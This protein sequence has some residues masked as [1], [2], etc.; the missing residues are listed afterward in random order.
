MIRCAPLLLMLG[1]SSYQVNSDAANGSDASYT[2]ANTGTGSSDTDS[3]T[4][5]GEVE[6]DF[7]TLPPAQT[8]IYVFVANPARDTVSRINV[9][10]LE[11]RTTD[12]GIDPDIVITTPDYTTAAVFNRG[13]DTVSLIDAD[14]L[15]IVT[16][17]VRDNFNNMKMSPDGRFVAVWHDIDAEEADDPP[18]DGLQSFN[19]TSFVDVLTGDHWPM[20]VGFNPRDVVFT[21]N[22]QTAAVVSDEYLAI[23][24]LTLEPILPH[25]IELDPGLL[26]APRAEEV[27]LSHDGTCLRSPA[28]RRGHPGGRSADLPGRSRA[29]GPQSY[30]SRPLPRWQRGR[31]A[32]SGQPGGVGPRR[33]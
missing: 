14:T 24:D 29:C 28:R 30:R 3:S 11:V 32:R 4:T 20:A 12:V 31:G 17:P 13:D 15:D 1:C 23:V 16:V 9:E 2:S 10:T 26:D 7:L 5:I 19:E 33:P 8:D 21:P 27:I 22:G 18:A 25:L 6:D